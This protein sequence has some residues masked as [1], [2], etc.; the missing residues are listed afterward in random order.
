[1]DTLTQ[2]LGMKKPLIVLAIPF[3][4]LAAYLCF[5]VYQLRT[6]PDTPLQPGEHHSAAK[7]GL[8]QIYVLFIIVFVPFATVCFLTSTVMFVRRA[9]QSRFARWALVPVGLL[10]LGIL[11]LLGMVIIDFT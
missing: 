5:H 1:M 2:R 9:R 4:L 3:V 8:I 6:M 7:H 10:L 11:V